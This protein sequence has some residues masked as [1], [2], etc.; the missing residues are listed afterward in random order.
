M[1]LRSIGMGV[2]L[3]LALSGCHYHGYGNN[4]FGGAAVGAAAGAIGGAIVGR[5]GV[6]AAVGA[7]AGAIV[8]GSGHYRG[9]KP[10]R[11]AYGYPHRR[12]RRHK[13]YYW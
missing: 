7:A 8:G 3:V 13:H 1:R 4:V 11:Y 12:H 2:A 6:G 5:P 10:R 9:Y